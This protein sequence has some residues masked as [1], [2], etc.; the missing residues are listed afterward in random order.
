MGQE[1]AKQIVDTHIDASSHK[2]QQE[3]KILK[4]VKAASPGRVWL[5]LGLGAA[6]HLWPLVQQCMLL[7]TT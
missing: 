2:T 3:K 4:L 7:H 5:D 1:T 6:A